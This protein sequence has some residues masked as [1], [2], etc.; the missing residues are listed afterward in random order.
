M[1]SIFSFGLATGKFAMGSNE[2]LGM[3]LAAVSDEDAD[4]QDSGTVNLE[5]PTQ[6]PADAPEK[7]YAGKRKRGAFTYDEL[8]AF[9]N[10]TVAVRDVA[11]AIRDN[12]PTNMH[13]ELYNSVMDM[14]DFTE[15]AIIAALGHLLNH[16][17]QGRSFVQMALP[18]RILWLRIY[19]SKHYCS[20]D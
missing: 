9:T 15:E 14:V 18:H 6:K 11:Q 13:P 20:S 2:A 4:T 12:K 19:L 10:M 16:K 7:P 5:V 17:G 1:H 3:P 8:L